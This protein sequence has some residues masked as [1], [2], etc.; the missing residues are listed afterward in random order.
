MGE[1]DSAERTL[2]GRYGKGFMPPPA[3]SRRR[4]FVF[5][6]SVRPCVHA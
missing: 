4:Y 6:L 5:G 2:L 3:I 1:S